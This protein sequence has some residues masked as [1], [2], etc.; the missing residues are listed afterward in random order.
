MTRLILLGLITL[1]LTGCNEVYPS[2][3]APT[4]L[5]PIEDGLRFLGIALVV[6]VLINVLG[7]CRKGGG[8]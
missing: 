4:D 3:V 1:A 2:P 8:S 6:G 7:Q 5:T